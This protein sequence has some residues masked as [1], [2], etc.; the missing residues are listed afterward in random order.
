L[1]AARKGEGEENTE[2]TEVSSNLRKKRMKD[3]QDRTDNEGNDGTT[4][5]ADSEVDPVLELERH[6]VEEKKDG[7]WER[8]ALATHP[9]RRRQEALGKAPPDCLHEKR[10][11]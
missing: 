11:R 1:E 9:R 10:L 7:K 8:S 5:V 4:S 6:S 2:R 3:A